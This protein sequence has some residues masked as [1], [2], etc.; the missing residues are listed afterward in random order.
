MNKI[1]QLKEWISTLKANL[2]KDIKDDFKLYLYLLNNEFIE[3]Y[4]QSSKVKYEEYFSKL[5]NSRKI[6]ELPPIFP[7]EEE[8]L[9]FFGINSKKERID[10]TMGEFANNVLIFKF[11][12]E[13]NIYCFYFLDFLDE[14]QIL[15]QGYLRFYRDNAEKEMINYLKDKG[16]KQFFEIHFLSYHL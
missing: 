8:N 10:G 14:K 11:K 2:T 13:E 15:K 4:L 12:T 6:T 3:E 7:L 16:A 5:S 1:P 9:K